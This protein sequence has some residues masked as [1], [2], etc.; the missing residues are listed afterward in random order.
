[1][2]KVAQH[3]MGPF[4]CSEICCQRGDFRQGVRT[5]QYIQGSG[6]ASV[7]NFMAGSSSVV[8][9]TGVYCSCCPAR[10]ILRVTHTGQIAL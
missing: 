8:G 9:K 2:P 6:A 10:K 1:M 7:Q 3:G 4:A 5:L